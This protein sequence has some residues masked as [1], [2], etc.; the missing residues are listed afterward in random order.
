MRWDQLFADLEGRL[1]AAADA[2]LSAEIADRLRSESARRSLADRIAAATG[3]AL[4]VACLGGATAT[5]AVAR[6]GPDWML[7]VEPNGVDVL[8]PLSGVAAVIGLPRTVGR[9][10]GGGAVGA[11]LGLG[12]ALRAVARDRLPVVLELTDATT[13]GGTVERVGRDYLELS[14]TTGS[15]RA[16]AT[17]GSY[18]TRARAVPTSAI[19]MI[20]RR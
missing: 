13:T 11:A 4:Q 6:T 16:R 2:E 14:D 7:L 15:V 9:A 12:S 20:R 18:A 8:I 5:G 19:A 1:A 10:G 3:S 17:G